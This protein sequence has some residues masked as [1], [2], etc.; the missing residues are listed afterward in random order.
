MSDKDMLERALAVL[1]T[2]DEK[3]KVA[4][5]RVTD[6]HLN[7]AWSDVAGLAIMISTHLRRTDPPETR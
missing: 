2:V 4:K 3:L 7:S 6:E 5:S 1:A